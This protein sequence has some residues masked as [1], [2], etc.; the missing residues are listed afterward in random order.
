MSN[1]CF[2][3]H[4][5]EPSPEEIRRLTQSRKHEKRIEQLTKERRRRDFVEKHLLVD[6]PI[7][8][9][10]LAGKIRL[11]M[12]KPEVEA[13]WGKPDDTNQTVGVWGILEQ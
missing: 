5:Y 1:G 13:S 7:A 10:I 4:N 11:G 3:T 2:S 8:I 9:C 6:D 12:T